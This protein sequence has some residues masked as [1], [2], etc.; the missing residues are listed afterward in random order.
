MPSSRPWPFSGSRGRCSPSCCSAASP[1]GSW[2]SAG[3]WPL[4]RAA[5]WG[6]ELWLAFLV[7]AVATAG[8]LFFSEVADF[9]PCE[10]CWYQRIFMYPLAIVTL[11]A[12]LANDHRVA[13]YLLPL[14]VLGAAFSVYHLL[15]EN[16]VVEQ[17]EGCRISAPGGCE[18]KWIDEL[19][20]VTIPTL[21]LTAFAAHV[22]VPAPGLARQLRR[23][24]GSPL[25]AG[26]PPDKERRASPRLL[27]AAAAVCVLVAIAIVL[28]VVLTGGSDDSEAG[29]TTA[30]E[31]T[32]STGGD[33]VDGARRRPCRRRSRFEDLLTGIPQDANELGDPDAPVTM[34][35]YVDIQ[36]PYCASVDTKVLPTLITRYVRT[37]KL[38]LQVRPLAGLG[39]DSERGRA[40]ILAAGNQGKLFDVMHLLY[41]N[42]GAENS[43]WLED[44]CVDRAAAS[45]RGLDAA[46]LKTDS[47][48]DEVGS[49]GERLPR[50]GRRGLGAGDADDSRR[51]ERHRAHPRAADL[52]RRPDC[53]R[54][55]DRESAWLGRRLAGQG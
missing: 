3:R 4:V 55:G 21:A 31:Q 35:E 37:G 49:P 13:R 11:L 46:R 42:Q 7:S 34:V 23:G 14:P 12:A 9:F 33:D 53:G 28:G 1:S 41:L 2:A 54:A 27:G 8:S 40:I 45:V 22:R 52:R 6:Y 10:L 20:Y 43:G 50:S 32:T 18:T 26:G 38:K 30:T 44:S 16:G 47:N 17:A 48:S 5:V 39:P 51:Q 25:M 36:C 19:G 29:E 24:Y 15:V